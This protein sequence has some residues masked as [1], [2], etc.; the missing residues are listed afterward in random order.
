MWE[1]KTV[2]HPP[3][4]IQEKQL[5][6]RTLAGQICLL[7]LR[8]GGRWGWGDTTVHYSKNGVLDPCHYNS[9][10]HMMLPCT[11]DESGHRCAPGPQSEE[12]LCPPPPRPVITSR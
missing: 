2:A 10:E 7:G 12:N 1:R 11:I 3:L 4:V 8:L 5:Q 9:A 6:S